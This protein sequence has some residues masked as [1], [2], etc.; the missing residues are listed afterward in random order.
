MTL[1]N[2]SRPSAHA[3]GRE[4][5]SNGDCKGASTQACN[6]PGGSPLARSLAVAA[7]I[8]L[9]H[10]PGHA[11]KEHREKAYCVALPGY[12]YEFPRDHFSHSCFRTEWW[13]FTGNVATADGRR[14]GYQ[15]TFFREAVDNPYPNPS[16]WRVDDLYLAHFAIS[17]IAGKDFFYT[18]RISRAGI[19]L[20]GADTAEARPA[21]SDSERARAFTI[22]R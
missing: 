11:Q 8:V 20:A 10:C 4:R 7:L 15:L 5:K 19:G 17:D 6:R 21:R 14:F 22:S 9:L 3:Q 1:M 13:Y 18:Q 2:P 16:R 12:R